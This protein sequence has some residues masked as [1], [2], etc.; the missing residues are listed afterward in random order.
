MNDKAEK[1]CRAIDDLLLAHPHKTLVVEPEA[2]DLLR[3]AQLR[4][5]AGRRIAAVGASRQE[6]SWKQLEA[7]LRLR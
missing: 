3:L 7:T 4:R 2:Q 1:L 5:D 6:E